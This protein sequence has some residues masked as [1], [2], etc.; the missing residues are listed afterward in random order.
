MVRRNME[1]IPQFPL[2][3][4]F[5]MRAMRKGDESA[6]A[7]ILTAA[8]GRL[9][10]EKGFADE[11][12]SDEAEIQKRVFF[13][14]SPEGEEIGTI[15]AWH[16]TDPEGHESGLIHWVGILPAYQRFGLGKASMSY[17]MNRMAEM[18]DTCYLHTS[19]ARL[20]AVKV[21]LDFGFELDMSGHDADKALEV[22]RSRLKHPSLD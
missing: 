15:S 4:G 7:R 17:T 9:I 16:W 19:T 14:I 20:A 6:W 21:Y 22:L 5:S 18:H 10:E 2:A 13:I 8:M 3:E 12:G 11:Y 1:N